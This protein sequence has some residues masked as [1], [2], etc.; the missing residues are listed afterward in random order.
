MLALATMLMLAITWQD[1]GFS[2]LSDLSTGGLLPVLLI[3]AVI[4]LLKT[5]LLSA[6]LLM[7]KKLWDKLRK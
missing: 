2:S 3:T 6:L 1:G 4:F 5:G 7:L